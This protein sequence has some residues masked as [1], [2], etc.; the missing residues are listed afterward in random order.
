MEFN[1]RQPIEYL[2]NEIFIWLMRLTMHQT[3][4]DESQCS[5]CIIIKNPNQIGTCLRSIKILYENY[6][7]IMSM[8]RVSKFYRLLIRN[9]FSAEV[10]IFHM[11][12]TKV[13]NDRI[14]NRKQNNFNSEKPYE[15]GGMRVSN[16]FT[17]HN[18][19]L[20]DE[21]FVKY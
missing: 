4:P 16:K 21:A 7:P 11:I 15:N 9:Y 1:H 13:C 3:C 14:L 20:P 2:P 6:Y 8:S 12:V 10:K 19:L 18:L 17:Q 5:N